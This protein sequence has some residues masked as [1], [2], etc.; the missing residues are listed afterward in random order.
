M[1][2]K[3]GQET[4]TT[5]DMATGKTEE[6]QR[7]SEGMADANED[8]RVSNYLVFVAIPARSTKFDYVDQLQETEMK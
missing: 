8:I 5:K 3:D 1:C 7:H 6:H 4:F 2:L